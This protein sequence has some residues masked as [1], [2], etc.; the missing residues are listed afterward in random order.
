MR[1]LLLYRTIGAPEY[2][3]PTLRRLYSFL[4]TTLVFA[5]ICQ[6]PLPAV[7]AYEVASLFWLA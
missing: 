2:G 6:L 4:T 7:P 3:P 1:V 5:P